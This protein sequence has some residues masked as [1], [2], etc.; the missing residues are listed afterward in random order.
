LVSD[1]VIA[2]LSGYAPMAPLHQAATMRAFRKD[3]RPGNR[4]MN[5][6]ER[7]HV[8]EA[9]MGFCIP[10]LSWALQEKMDLDD[11]AVGVTYDHKKS[12]NIRIGHTA[13]FGFCLWHHLGRIGM[14]SH[15][16]MRRKFGP[17]LMDGGKLFEEAYGSNDE[18]I[19]LQTY[20]LESE[21]LQ[22]MLC[23]RAP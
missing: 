7:M 11:V 5:S 19:A 3:R 8:S 16:W 2:E 13:G 23:A 20:A 4:P 17:S 1:E 12:G 22:A 15:D 6:V 10:C 14:R 9:R 18:L 21:G